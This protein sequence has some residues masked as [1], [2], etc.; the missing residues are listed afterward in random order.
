MSEDDGDPEVPTKIARL[1]LRAELLEDLGAA[2]RSAAVVYRVGHHREDISGD[3]LHVGRQDGSARRG[4][5]GSRGDDSLGWHPG[6]LAPR[7]SI[8]YVRRGLTK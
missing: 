7:L 2:F 4:S 3:P 6:G 8:G 5:A 1:A